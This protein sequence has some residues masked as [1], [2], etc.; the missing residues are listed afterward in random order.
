MTLCKNKLSHDLLQVIQQGFSTCIIWAMTYFGGFSYSLP[1]PPLPNYYLFNSKGPK[2]LQKGVPLTPWL[3]SW[4]WDKMSSPD[5][6]Y[7]HLL[8]MIWY[9]KS[10]EHKISNRHYWQN[11]NKIIAIVSTQK[12]NP[13][14]FVNTNTQCVS[15]L[16]G[17]INIIGAFCWINFHV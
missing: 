4:I 6:C 11:K 17:L 14:Y 10:T 7:G 3:Q 1:F 8:R 12:A 2:G 9:V 13:G 16:G 15:P 5:R